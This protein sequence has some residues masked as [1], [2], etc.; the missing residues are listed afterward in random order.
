LRDSCAYIYQ[1]LKDELFIH[2]S[3][4]EFP[5]YFDESLQTLEGLGLITRENAGSTARRPDFV[6]REFQLLNMFGRCLGS[7]I[8]RFAVSSAFLAKFESRESFPREEFEK[9]CQLMSQRIAILNGTS[10]PEHHDQHIFRSQFDML[11]QFS[12]IERTTEEGRYR[13]RHG[14]GAAAA[15]SIGLLSHDLRQTITRSS[16]AGDTGVG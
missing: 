15:Q 9:A 3:A 12:Y 2:F 6:T 8:E 5:K 4:A 13:V 10:E 7:T 1:F 16:P 11:K 14:A